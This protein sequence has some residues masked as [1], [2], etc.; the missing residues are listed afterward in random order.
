MSLYTAVVLGLGL[1]MT[2]AC[3]VVVTLAAVR[4]YNSRREDARREATARAAAYDQRRRFFARLES[5]IHIARAD[6]GG[7][8]GDF[9]AWERELKG[10]TR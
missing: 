2:T 1:A 5:T 8:D 7:S 3:A 10:Q 6:F 4:Y 9:T